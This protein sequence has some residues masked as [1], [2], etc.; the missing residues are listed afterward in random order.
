MSSK[1]FERSETMQLTEGAGLWVQAEVSS[2]DPSRA[3][4]C[5]LLIAA[6]AQFENYMRDAGVTDMEHAGCT[7]KSVSVL[8]PRGNKVYR[9]CNHALPAVITALTQ[10]HCCC[11]QRATA[12]A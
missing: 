11:Q 10:A 9:E 5:A 7:P 12:A 1:V 2:A 3:A 6:R 8:D 4:A